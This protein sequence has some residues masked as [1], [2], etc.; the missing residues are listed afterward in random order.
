M[1]GVVGRMFGLSVPHG[2]LEECISNLEEGLR[3][4]RTTPYHAVLG[5]SFLHHLDSA[6]RLIGDFYR[7]SS[8]QGPIGAIYCEMNGFTINTSRWFFNA[9]GYKQEEN[10]WDL[11]WE[12]EWLSSWDAETDDFNL[13]GM[14][15]V[16]D[17]FKELY[18]DRRQ[19]LGVQLAGE[20]TEYLVVARFNEL[21]GAAHDLAKEQC[22][23]LDGFPILSTAHDWD[24]LYPSQ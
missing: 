13:T 10:L 12:T 19:P 22:S 1:T 23:E 9:F 3:A 20:V 17:A 15:L 6:A 2:K 14:E 11:T 21:I 5:C 8:N 16:Q 4:I 24:T 18:G 7:A